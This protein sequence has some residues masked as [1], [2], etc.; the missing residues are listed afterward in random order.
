MRNIS[1]GLAL[2]IFALILSL[3]AFAISV[4]AADTVSI[5]SITT[6]AANHGQAIISGS[7]IYDIGTQTD[8]NVDGAPAQTTTATSWTQT[9]TD[10]KA[11]QHTATAIV[12][13]VSA[14]QAFGVP[15]NEGGIICR[16]KGCGMPM[17]F[18]A[19]MASQAPVETP[20]VAT[21]E[22]Q[23]KE[24]LNVLI[25]Q[26]IALLILRVQELQTQLA[27]VQ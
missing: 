11:G 22:A 9:F 16:E 25:K 10:L 5:D 23:M 8:V 21:T 17:D 7:T 20:V 1:Y 27:L 6:S 13:G 18:Q 3:F 14:S 19:L 15:S 4:L 24:Q 12:N 26:V 2:S